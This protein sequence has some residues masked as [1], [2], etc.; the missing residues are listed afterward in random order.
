MAKCLD[1]P[2]SRTLSSLERNLFT[3]NIAERRNNLKKWRTKFWASILLLIN[4]K[5]FSKLFA[6]SKQAKFRAPCSRLSDCYRWNSVY[7]S[8]QVEQQRSFRST[9]HLEQRFGRW[10]RSQRRD[11]RNPQDPT[12]S[13]CFDDEESG[14]DVRGGLYTSVWR[15]RTGQRRFLEL[16]CTVVHE[17]GKSPDRFQQ[18]GSAFRSDDRGGHSTQS[19]RY[20]ET[21]SSRRI[22]ST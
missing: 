14:S 22:R 15:A 16:C 13:E 12:I 6:K 20:R 18:N 2:I 21:E 7:R 9:S 4:R 8:N 11:S 5:L 3:K 1:Y 10:T 17:A 19:T